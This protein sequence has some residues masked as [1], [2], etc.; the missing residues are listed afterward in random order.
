MND[1]RQL[2]LQDLGR[3]IESIGTMLKYPDISSK[4]IET[5]ASLLTRYSV[6]VLRVAELAEIEDELE[7][8]EEFNA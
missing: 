4:A 2:I 5:L 3:S 6:A 1:N 7:E 8:M